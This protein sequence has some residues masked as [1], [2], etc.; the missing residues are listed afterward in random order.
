MKKLIILSL[1]ALSLIACGG[2]GFV[3][4]NKNATPNVAPN[5]PNVNRESPGNTANSNAAA[6]TAE[7]VNKTANANTPKTAASNPERVVFPPGKTFVNQPLVIAPGDSKEF[8]VGAKKGQFLIVEPESSKPS[9][10][11]AK[12]ALITKGKAEVTD[13]SAFL[14][15]VLNADGDYVFEVKN[16]TKQEL[17]MIMHVQIDKGPQ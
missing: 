5:A 6:N 14:S 4:T 11:E 10:S 7:N 9:P 15:A 8:V 3:D 1:S 13:L 12:I 2:S 16:L 17:K